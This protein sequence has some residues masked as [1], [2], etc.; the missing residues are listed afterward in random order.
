[1]SPPCRYLSKLR[2]AF[3]LADGM[4]IGTRMFTHSSQYRYIVL[5]VKATAAVV[6]SEIAAENQSDVPGVIDLTGAGYCRR[7]SP[8][9]SVGL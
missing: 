3:A 1:M 5:F 7:S 6:E 8:Q 4:D 2:R 9:D